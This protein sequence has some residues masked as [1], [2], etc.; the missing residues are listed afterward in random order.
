MSKGKTYNGWPSYETWL[1]HLHLTNTE[2]TLQ[3]CYAHAMISASRA[4]NMSQVK[5]KIWT[6]EEARVFDLADE[7]KRF[8]TDA[9]EL[10]TRAEQAFNMTNGGDWSPLFVADLIKSSLDEVDWQ[11]IAEAFLEGAGIGPG[12]SIA[13][14]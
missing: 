2:N 7:I 14:A 1:V 6:V 11:K 3:T 9:V 13:Q 12:W 10:P 4:P 5:D 8:V